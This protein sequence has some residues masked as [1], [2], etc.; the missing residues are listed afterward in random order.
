MAQYKY[1]MFTGGSRVYWGFMKTGFVE[2]LGDDC[3]PITIDNTDMAGSLTINETINDMNG[4]ILAD[5]D[6]IEYTSYDKSRERAVVR[7]NENGKLY[8]DNRSYFVPW[9][10]EDVEVVGSVN[11][12]CGFNFR[13]GA[14]NALGGVDGV[15]Y[16]RR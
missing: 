6:I 13:C 5:G 1:R 8:F 14:G 4:N 2:M 16:G 15:R 10:L 3:E 9:Y 7:F 12:L 11:R